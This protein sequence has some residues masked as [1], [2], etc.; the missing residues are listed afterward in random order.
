MKKL[1][2]M[3]AAFLIVTTSNF[4]SFAGQWQQNNIGW[5]WQND[6]GS[7]PTNTWQYLDGN[8]DGI[9]EWY[10]FDING[11][12][13]KGWQLV[14]G[15]WY[16][17]NEDGA[18]LS[19]TFTPDG[20]YVGNDGAMIDNSKNASSNDWNYDD[21]FDDDS[22]DDDFDDEI[23]RIMQEYNEKKEERENRY[24]QMNAELE[25]DTESTETDDYD[26]NAQS[27]D[28]NESN[29]GYEVN[30]SEIKRKLA[31]KFS[32]VN[33]GIDKWKLTYDITKNSSS[34]H[35]WDAWIQIDWKGD[36]TPYDLEYSIDY[37]EDEKETAIEALK[38]I[39]YQIYEYL[40]EE[41]PNVKVECGFYSGFYKYRHV[42]VGY[43]TIRF[44]TWT[45]FG[46]VLQDY[47]ES[48]IVGFGW[49]DYADSYSFT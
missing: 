26:D 29:R 8:Q 44:C 36:V 7:Y 16:Y 15:K 6:D 18:M 19:N 30:T 32:S 49:E 5:W 9:S 20:Y 34:I 23:Q 27:K 31:K 13:Q 46:S 25:Q 38:D 10:R 1:V 4:V 48:S 43:D 40:S 21:S 12:M 39:Q 2:C 42:K 17:M 37:S 14:D 28:N 33:I 35:P 41:Y 3:L 45:N 24:Q 22:F 11:Y 47:S